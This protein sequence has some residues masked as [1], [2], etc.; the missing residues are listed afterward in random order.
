MVTSI[1]KQSNQTWAYIV[2]S[3]IQEHSPKVSA[4][5][6]P[7]SSDDKTKRQ[8]T[9]IDETPDKNHMSTT[10]DLHKEI[11]GRCMETMDVKNNH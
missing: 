1:H 10:P 7:L 4:F 6:N 5:Q 2:S 8:S 11:D 3:R 9:F